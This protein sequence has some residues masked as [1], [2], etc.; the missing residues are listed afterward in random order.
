MYVYSMRGIVRR[1]VHDVRGCIRSVGLLELARHPTLE[2]T[3]A[4]ELADCWFPDVGCRQPALGGAFNLA[5]RPVVRLSARAGC[6]GGALLVR[7]RLRA[8]A[9]AFVRRRARKRRGG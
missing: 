4:A 1:N 6:R 7:D 2:T 8:C 3:L 9:L 5:F